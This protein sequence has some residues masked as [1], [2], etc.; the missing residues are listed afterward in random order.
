MQELKNIYCPQCGTKL[1]GDAKFCAKCGY[2]INYENN[3]SKVNTNIDSSKNVQKNKM[4]YGILGAIAA[5][6]LL[7]IG[8]LA[9]GHFDKKEVKQ[10]DS[11]AIS[12]TTS[13][14]VQ[15]EKLEEV[16]RTT[17][18]KPKEPD[19]RDLE[20]TSE[21]VYFD[22]ERNLYRFDEVMFERVGNRHMFVLDKK[23]NKLLDLY[24]PE[25]TTQ[26]KDSGDS[27][28]DIT[29]R[30][31][32]IKN[33]SQVF[34]QVNMTTG[35][36]AKLEGFWIIGKKNGEWISFISLDNLKSFGFDETEYHNLR[37]DI[38]NGKL[39]INV[40]H[41]VTPPGK[42]SYQAEKVDDCNVTA[43]WDNNAGTFRMY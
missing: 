21:A 37:C 41:M 18:N 1:D 2:K 23:G 33:S 40:F 16:N 13:S 25:T 9:Y 15:S 24:G 32:R 19:I 35:A 39:D 42:A 20:Y 5:I 34:Y 28:A 26:Y 14:E 10:T 17:D 12:T 36:H 30:E 22:G 8:Y 38:I 29:V 7:G 27:Y 6:L 3:S 31:F 4:L 43:D 11:S